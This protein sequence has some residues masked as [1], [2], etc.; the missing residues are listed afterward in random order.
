MGDRFGTLVT[1]AIG[2]D[3]NYS[4]WFDYKDDIPYVV[5][6]HLIGQVMT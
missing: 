5:I 3:N 2:S 4:Y 6:K 1:T